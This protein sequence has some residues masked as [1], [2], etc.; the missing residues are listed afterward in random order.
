M[1]RHL[2]SSVGVQLAFIGFVIVRTLIKV[3]FHAVSQFHGKGPLNLSPAQSPSYPG[4]T[5]PMIGINR[6]YAQ[7]G[8]FGSTSFA[9]ALFEFPAIHI[10][11][12]FLPNAISIVYI[13]V[14]GKNFS[15]KQIAEAVPE[16][17]EGH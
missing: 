17:D 9:P 2:K 14:L 11:S 4:A 1:G 10:R 13:G 7:F 3:A 16:F 12:P 8:C 15:Q 6:T 5:L